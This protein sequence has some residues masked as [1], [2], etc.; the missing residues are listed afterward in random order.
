MVWIAASFCIALLYAWS[1]QLAVAVSLLMIAC[2]GLPHG[3]A[4]ALR[5]WQRWPRWFTWAKATSIYALI[6][7]GFAVFFYYF[8][9]PGLI[10]FVLISI[11]HFGAQDSIGLPA[12]AA[13][14]FGGLFIFGPFLFWQ[15]DI[16]NYF[17]QLGLSHKQV[18]LW[19]SAGPWL[20]LICCLISVTASVKKK[21]AGRPALLALSLCLPV[22]VGLP[23]L[24]SFSLYFSMLHAPRHS[25]QLQSEMPGWWRHPLVISTVLVTWGLAAW[26]LLAG[27]GN[28]LSQ[29]AVQG[30][31]IGMAS[32]TLP[33]MFLDRYL[34]NN[35]SLKCG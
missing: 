10:I 28:S 7:L 16:A 1:A 24:L 23:P 4:D 2:L 9:L 13:L 29:R 35:A 5:M 34:S 31:I 25:R 30:L 21:S 32:V 11:W 14:G 26:W 6:T 33:H 12:W 17:L 3:A 15:K 8:P 20:F 27:Y 19:L 22:A 18:T